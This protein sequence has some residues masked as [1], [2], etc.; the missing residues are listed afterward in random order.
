M[1]NP[2]NPKLYNNLERVFGRVRV[3]NEGEAMVARYGFN[4]VEQEITMNIAHAGEYYMV[5]CPYCNDTRFRLYI[6]HRWGVKDKKTGRRNLWLSVCY[7]ESCLSDPMN[8]DDL[9][10]RLERTRGML[11]SVQIRRGVKIDPEKLERVEPPGPITRLHHL[12]PN[13]PANR[14][15]AERMYDPEMLS[16]CYGV[17]YC[18]DS[19]HWLARNRIYVPI[20]FK[21]KIRGYQ[22]R[23]I[24]E[25]DWKNE[26]EIPKWWTGPGTKKSLLLYN[27][28]QAI[29]YRTGVIVEGGG[30]VWGFGPMSLATLGDS[31]SEAQLRLLLSGFR[32]YSTVLLWDPE[33]LEPEKESKR[34]KLNNAIESLRR[35]CKGGFAVVSLPEGTDP[36][37]LDRGFMRDYV[38]SEAKAQGVKVSWRKR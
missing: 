10:N 37:S 24:G 6:N 16:R 17:G 33:A 21:G 23:Y 13:H 18:P 15:L 8:L 1:N 36:G 19:I 4:S 9:V 27:Y 2:L 7:N 30:D 28:D 25:L 32:E 5:C 34:I 26:K 29:K 12:P 35:G 3:C 31:L 20:V 22:T 11:A 38:A 14:Y